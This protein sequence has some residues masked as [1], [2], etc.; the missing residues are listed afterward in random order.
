M[1]P[2]HSWV[3][4]FRADCV[5]IL[6]S[7]P[8]IGQKC[9]QIWAWREV[10]GWVND[11]SPIWASKNT[12]FFCTH[13]IP[14][15]WLSYHT[16]F[17]KSTSKSVQTDRNVHL[18]NSW[19]KLPSAGRCVGQSSIHFQLP[20][21]SKKNLLPIFLHPSWSSVFWDMTSRV[22]NARSTCFPGELTKC[23][24]VLAAVSSAATCS[25][26]TSISLFILDFGLPFFPFYWVI[27]DS[28]WCV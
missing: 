4:S 22:I 14:T 6:E 19:T 17:E 7:L 8:T 5:A 9:G 25:G 11:L 27:Y 16:H 1:N 10:E 15:W 18:Q 26:C 12:H 2:C 20:E 3:F 23:F 13:D 28:E 24:T 21:N